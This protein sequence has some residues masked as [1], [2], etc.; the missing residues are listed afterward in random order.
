MDSDIGHP[1]SRADCDAL[2]CTTQNSLI[3]FRFALNW[4]LKLAFGLYLKFL[5]ATLS[6]NFQKCAAF[7]CSK[8]S[9]TAGKAQHRNC[10]R[11]KCGNVW[12]RFR[13]LLIPVTYFRTVFSRCRRIFLLQ[14]SVHT[15]CG[16]W[17]ISP[18]YFNCSK[19]FDPF[20]MR[21]ILSR[22]LH[23]ELFRA[24]LSV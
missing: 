7:M 18:S 12:N 2:T 14:A 8:Y 23:A 15:T 16:P 17:L 11:P 13:L 20:E 10:C 21:P 9:L 24:V 19:V 6:P 3:A 22:A 4:H 1:D 5:V